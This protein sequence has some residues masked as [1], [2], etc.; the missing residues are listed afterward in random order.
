MTPFYAELPLDKCNFRSSKIGLFTLRLRNN[1]SFDLLLPNSQKV[2]L[3][4]CLET[5]TL[6]KVVSKNTTWQNTCH[7]KR[8]GVESPTYLR[9]I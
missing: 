1:K 3:E 6:A 2:L 7:Y 4:L 9:I 8:T 5:R